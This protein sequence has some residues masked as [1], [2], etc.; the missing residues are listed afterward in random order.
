MWDIAQTM[1][2]SRERYR[3]GFRQAKDAGVMAPDLLRCSL[4]DSLWL[5]REEGLREVGVVHLVEVEIVVAVV[6]G[7]DRRGM[8]VARGPGKGGEMVGAGEVDGMKSGDRRLRQGL[9]ELR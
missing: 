9:K 2:G 1:L 4:D 7:K 8:V 5:T 6:M 3:I